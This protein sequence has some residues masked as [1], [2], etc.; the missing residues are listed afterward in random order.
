M[1]KG[2]PERKRNVKPGKE[3]GQGSL[4]VLKSKDNVYENLKPTPVS[5]SSWKFCVVHPQPSLSQT[6]S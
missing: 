5:V 3:N 1:V 2:A 6:T 4:G